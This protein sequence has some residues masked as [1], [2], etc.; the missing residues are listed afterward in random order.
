MAFSAG[1]RGSW[2]SLL[3]KSFTG[4]SSSGSVKTRLFS[5]ALKGQN[6]HSKLV[7]SQIPKFQQQPASSWYST[8]GHRPLPKEKPHDLYATLRLSPSATQQQVKEA[9]Y[10]LSMKY[11][12]DRNRGSEE[13]HRKFTEITEAYSI[14]GQYELRKK[15][16]KGL[17]QQFPGRHPTH[18][19]QYVKKYS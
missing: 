19:H 2:R 13:A 17:L 5:I 18:K 8:R 7:G 14:L 4:A 12:P 10:A 15:Y 9:Y 16:D 1:L 6:G 11:H 3:D